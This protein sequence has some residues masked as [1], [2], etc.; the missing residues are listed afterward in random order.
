MAACWQRTWRSTAEAVL[1]PPEACLSS[2]AAKGLSAPPGE[3]RPGG[4]MA[5][6]A[7]AKGDGSAALPIDRRTEEAGLAGGSCAARP[8][9]EL[10]TLLGAVAGERAPAP[11]PGS[12][13]CGLGA[14]AERS[15]S[16]R[17]VCGQGGRAAW[18]R[19]R[20]MRLAGSIGS[21]RA[22]VQRWG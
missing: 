1:P 9:S 2:A 20:R 8:S 21:S 22:Q 3:A 13:C 6:A 5:A 19:Q 7:A 4:G 14:T 11:L 12:S 17:S 15:T 18:Q 16:A 10:R